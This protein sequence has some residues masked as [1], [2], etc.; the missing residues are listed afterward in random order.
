MSSSERG[1][2]TKDLLL[3][4]VQH[5]VQQLIESLQDSNDCIPNKTN[6]DRTRQKEQ[7]DGEQ[8][9]RRRGELGRS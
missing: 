6:K 4:L 2:R 9:D 3:H 8:V 7:T 1:R 5:Q